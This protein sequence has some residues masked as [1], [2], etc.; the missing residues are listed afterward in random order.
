MVHVWTQVLFAIDKLNA[1][2]SQFKYEHDT[3][4]TMNRHIVYFKLQSFLSVPLNSFK[5]MFLAK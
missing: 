1:S 2:F 3:E 5:I 4:H